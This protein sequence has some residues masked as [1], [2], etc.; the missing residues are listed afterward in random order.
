M[1]F[2]GFSADHPGDSLFALHPGDPFAATLA[3]PD[4]PVLH[5]WQL[6]P[7][8]LEAS[9][10]ALG[11]AARVAEALAMFAGDD[12]DDGDDGS[13]GGG[14]GGGGGGGDGGAP[15][16]QAPHHRHHHH[17][18]HHPGHPGG[19]HHGEFGVEPPAPFLP[20]SEFYDRRFEQ[21]YDEHSYP[22]APMPAPG[23][24]PYGYPHP[25][26]HPGAHPGGGGAGSVAANVLDPMH[27][28]HQHPKNVGDVLK[29]VFDPL[30]IFGDPRIERREGPFG[31]RPT[32]RP[33]FPPLPPHIA[34]DPFVS[35]G[36]GDLGRRHYASRAEYAVRG[37]WQPEIP[38]WLAP[39]EQGW[40]TTLTPDQRQR[41]LTLSPE[42]RHYW[43]EHRRRLTAAPPVP[44]PPPPPPP[45]M[46]W[47]RTHHDPHVDPHAMQTS[48][49]PDQT[50]TASSPPATSAPSV[51]TSASTA[52]A[53]SDGSLWSS[54]TSLPSSAWHA[55]T[56]GGGP[57]PAAPDS[58]DAATSD[59][60]AA[61][62]VHGEL[63][64]TFYR[65][66]TLKF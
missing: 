59:S 17:G 66:N 45:A 15:Q 7:G 30:H 62:G 42:Q 29:N 35:R 24:P 27:L 34:R 9:M 14:D 51:D 33:A 31:L 4:V 53:S 54:I 21:P 28:F 55:L 10:H 37:P 49:W 22:G 63:D 44:F 65:R 38:S 3:A 61:A 11:D 43:L 20:H 13:D 18:G 16:A 39:E 36:F 47:D 64:P 2:S 52:A 12:D 8:L 23:Y 56:G 6:P 19:H 50:A 48:P 25:A 5:H 40:W 60:Q 26:H 1:S 41:W 58:G 32:P 46:P 57:S